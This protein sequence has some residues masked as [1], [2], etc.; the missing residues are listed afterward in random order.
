VFK[1]PV[2]PAGDGSESGKKQ[3][4]VG[5]QMFWWAALRCVR[6]AVIKR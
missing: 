5:P 3:S 4:G 2:S 6:K 1:A